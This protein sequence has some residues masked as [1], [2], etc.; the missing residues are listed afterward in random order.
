MEYQKLFE[1]FDTKGRLRLPDTE[2]SFGALAWNE[3]PAFKGVALKHLVT[4]KDTGGQFSC[5]LVRVAPGKAIGEH[6]HKAQTETHEVIA[7]GGVCVNGGVR[8]AYEPGVI[9][10]LPMGSPHSVTAGPDGLYL[11][12]K[13]IPALT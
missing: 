12:A 4:A 10:I 2:V 8:L 1:A 5:H 13:F 9:S 6:V 11:F 3:H 7:G